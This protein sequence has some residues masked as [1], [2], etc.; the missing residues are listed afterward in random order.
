MAYVSVPRDMTKVK[1]KVLLNLTFRQIVCFGSAAVIGVPTYFL[2][3]GTIGN[4]GAVLIMIA[5][6][7]PAFFI[8]MYER[9]GQPAEKI[10][11]NILR[12]RFFFPAIRPYKTENF[13]HII[14]KEAQF[15][16]K[17]PA[18][19]KTGKTPVTKRKTG[20]VQQK[21]NKS[22]AKKAIPKTTSKIR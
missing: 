18:A 15:A 14:E 17:K 21:G 11:R 3:R 7:L 22:G 8:A 10:L 4:S 6:M 16:G 20:K 12:S 19:G 5:L 9:D 2:T 1:T 13:Y